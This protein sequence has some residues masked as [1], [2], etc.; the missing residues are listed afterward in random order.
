MYDRQA[1]HIT[2]C[3]DALYIHCVECK[4]PG[5]RE[6]LHGPHNHQF[7]KGWYYHCKGL[8]ERCRWCQYEWS[9]NSIYVALYTG[10]CL[11]WYGI[12]WAMIVGK[13]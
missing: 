3:N 6:R 7:G 4:D 2:W 5:H 11:M 13:E 8:C 12:A 9:Q 1:A 10:F